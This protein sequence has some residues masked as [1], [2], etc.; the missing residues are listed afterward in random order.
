[1]YT[2]VDPKLDAIVVGH[3][4]PPRENIEAGAGRNIMKCP[5]AVGDP[6]RLL[7]TGSGPSTSASSRK[8]APVRPILVEIR[9]R[10]AHFGAAVPQIVHTPIFVGREGSA[11]LEHQRGA[12]EHRLAPGVLPQSA[13]FSLGGRRLHTRGT[14]KVERPRLRLHAWG[15]PLAVRGMGRRYVAFRNTG[16]ESRLHG[17]ASA[18]MRPWASICGRRSADGQSCAVKINHP[19]AQKHISRSQRRSDTWSKCRTEVACESSRPACN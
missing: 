6:F 18:T 7:R 9:A 2:G 11:V 13:S 5:K 8:V 4:S 3:V 19:D 17:G 14:A 12:A 1:M 16:A 10:R 15:V